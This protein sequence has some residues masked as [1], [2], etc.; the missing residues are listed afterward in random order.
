MGAQGE[1]RAPSRDCSHQAPQACTQDGEV[2]DGQPSHHAR[3][4]GE[5]GG[6]RE[7]ALQ[8]WLG[9]AHSSEEAAHLEGG[10]VMPQLESRWASWATPK[11]SACRL[12]FALVRLWCHCRAWARIAL[13]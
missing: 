6:E 7:K 1:V 9:T 8:A 3:G 2:A 5:E 11:A 13:S 10:A 4:E 12:D